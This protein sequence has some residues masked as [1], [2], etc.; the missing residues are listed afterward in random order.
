MIKSP[1]FLGFIHPI[2]FFLAVC[3]LKNSVGY[4]KKDKPFAVFGYLPEYRLSNFDY[5]GVFDNGLTHL[6]FF[7]L[8]VDG[9]TSLP[10]ALDRLP[11]K[12][13]LQR[14]RQAADSVEGKLLIS[15]GGNSRSEGFSRMTSTVK[16]R[17]KFLN[18]LDKLLEEYDFDGIDYNWEYPQSAEEWDAWHLLMMESKQLLL[19]HRRKEENNSETVN[20]STTTTSNIDQNSNTNNTDKKVVR[21]SEPVVTFTMYLDANHYKVIEHFDLLATA[22]YVHCMAYDARGKHSTLEFAKQGN[23]SYHYCCCHSLLDI[24]IIIIISLF[25]CIYMLTYCYR[26]RVS[27]N[28]IRISHATMDTRLAILRTEHKDRGA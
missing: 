6:I 22:D 27:S 12:D 13:D 26:Y 21:S 14:A 28:C 5:E 2:V 11:S 8:E 25:I 10:K 17:H 20:L 3:L 7:S 1:F 23:Y 4:S 9:R 16:N 24:I 18:A 15:F 19:K